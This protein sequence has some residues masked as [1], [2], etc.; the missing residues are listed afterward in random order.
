MEAADTAVAGKSDC[1]RRRVD[2]KPTRLGFGATLKISMR[3]W[4]LAGIL[5]GMVL[6]AGMLLAETEFE[7]ANI[8]PAAQPT[9]DLFRS[10]KIHIGMTVTKTRVD[11][12]GMP[13]TTLIQDAYR[14]KQFQVAAPEWAGQSRWDILAKLPDG[15]SED[16]VPDMLQAL[17]ADRF[18]LTIH[19]EKREQPVYELVVGKAG[20][21]L[22]ASDPAADAV[23]APSAA[24]AADGDA[25]GGAGRGGPPGLFPGF[26]GP[27][28]G[29]GNVTINDDGRGGR[30]GAVITGGAGGT[31]RISPSSNCGMHIEFS[32][33][34]MATLADTL[35]SFLDKP[36]VDDTELKG[37]YKVAMD[38]PMEVMFGMIQN[39]ARSAGLPFGG[40]GGPGGGGPGGPGGGG[41]GG[42]GGFGDGPGGALAGCPDPGAALAAGADSSTAPIFQAV[43]QLGLKLQARKAPFDTI[44]VDHLEKAP[45]EN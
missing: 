27:F 30:G 34:T 29:G 13:L 23:P 8:T 7:V 40:P 26:G 12:G 11:I 18:K 36:V 4:L 25:P 41:P 21:K 9:P 15:A 22:E 19:H 3:N 1:I 10:G 16:Q 31:T 37:S 44:V 45:T 5:A 28:G 33:L 32:K 20:A 17:L 43:Q 2:G 6:A 14:V 38:L 39:M 35:G 24:G 42:R